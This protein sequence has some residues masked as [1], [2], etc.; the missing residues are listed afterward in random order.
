[1]SGGQTGK[2]GGSGGGGPGGT[3]V[4]FGVQWKDSGDTHAPCDSIDGV[5]RGGDFGTHD[6]GIA[7]AT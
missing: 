5:M 2:A 7:K 6:G 1:M 3:R 4:P